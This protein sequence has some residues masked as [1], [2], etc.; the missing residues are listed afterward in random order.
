MLAS[1][2]RKKSKKTAQRISLSLDNRGPHKCSAEKRVRRGLTPT[3]RHPVAPPQGDGLP[4][5]TP[6]KPGWLN[7][8]EGKEWLG[9]PPL[10]SPDLW[11]RKVA[12]DLASKAVG[13]LRVPRH[14]L[15]RTSLGIAPQGMGTSLTLEVTP[16]PPQ[17]LEQTAPLHP[18]MTVSRMASGGTPRKPS[19]RRSARISAMASARLSR[20]S[21]GV[22][23]CPLAPGISRQ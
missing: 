9:M 8:S 15:H 6:H 13:D 11:H 22:W 5:D 7:P 21:S 17:M 4:Q 3:P 10:L 1:T 19:S 18:T 23:P 20:A 16:V 14:R 2:R 12:T